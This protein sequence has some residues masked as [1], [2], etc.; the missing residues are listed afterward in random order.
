MSPIPHLI[1][2]PQSNEGALRTRSDGSPDIV[3]FVALSPLVSLWGY[4]TFWGN[5]YAHRVW[6]VSETLCRAIY[7]AGCLMITG[8]KKLCHLIA[9]R[10]AAPQVTASE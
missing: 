7:G 4:Y 8:V 10:K 3:F 5:T 1:Q 9:V 2:T 6:I